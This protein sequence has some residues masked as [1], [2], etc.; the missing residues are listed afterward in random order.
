MPGDCCL[1]LNTGL[2]APP[3]SAASTKNF[4]DVCGMELIRQKDFLGVKDNRP[5]LCSSVN[6]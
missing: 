1:G 5:T 4:N 2:V 6:A 3:A